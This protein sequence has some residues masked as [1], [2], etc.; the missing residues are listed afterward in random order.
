M[1]HVTESISRGDVIETNIY[2]DQ[3]WYLQDIHGFITCAETSYHINKYNK[4][5]KKLY[6]NLSFSSDLNKT[7]Y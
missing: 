1:K 4:I 2:T 5:K 7:K 6:Y 3:N